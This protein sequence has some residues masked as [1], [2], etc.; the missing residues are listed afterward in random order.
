MPNL[1]HHPS[2]LAGGNPC[3][4]CTTHPPERTQ[5]PPLVLPDKQERLAANNRP[6]VTVSYCYHVQRTDP[7]RPQSSQFASCLLFN[8]DS[9][10]STNQLTA[11]SLLNTAHWATLLLHSVTPNLNQFSAHSDISG[12]PTHARDFVTHSSPQELHLAVRGAGT[13]TK[14]TYTPFSLPGFLS[15]YRKSQTLPVPL[16]SSP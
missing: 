3:H 10:H 2:P 12:S 5:V 8:G 4:S 6:R 7:R 14:A 15:N 16:L 11:L 9:R 13:T 1:V